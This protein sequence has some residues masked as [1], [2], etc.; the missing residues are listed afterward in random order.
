M[1][2]LVLILGFIT[3]YSS[4]ASGYGVLLIM[5]LS[6][7]QQV[8]TDTASPKLY[9][10][11]LPDAPNGYKPEAGDCPSN[12]PTIRSASRLSQNE[13][14][15][16]QVRRNKTVDPMRDFLGRLDFG[17]F[18]AAS[19]ISD[20]AQNVSVLPNIAI[21]VSGGGYRALMNGG[22]DRQS[23]GHTPFCSNLG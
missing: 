6:F 5:L 2:Y 23:I 9:D 13:T 3:L 22:E 15:W 20:N 12:R 16:L 19:Y 21:A 17:N 1:A 11:A 10:R 7:D 4:F 8:L 18:K 14:S